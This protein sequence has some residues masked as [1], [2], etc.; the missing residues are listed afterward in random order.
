MGDDF[1][2]FFIGYVIGSMAG[3][4]LGYRA[5]TKYIPNNANQEY[6]NPTSIEFKVADKDF[7]GKKET[8]TKIN[9][10]DYIFKMEKG[11][12]VLLPYSI[13]ISTGAK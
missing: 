11:N 1:W 10:K 6:V 9:G 13:K 8:Y 5:F 3:M 7:D 4:G 2:K 12:P